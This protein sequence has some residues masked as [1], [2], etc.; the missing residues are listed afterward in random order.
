MR[1]SDWSSDVCSSDLQSITTLLHAVTGQRVGTRTLAAVR[2]LGPMTAHAAA[3]RDIQRIGL[4][5][6]E[7]MAR[8]HLEAGLVVGNVVAL[9][10]VGRF[11]CRSGTAL[12]PSHMRG[13]GDRK[14]NSRSRSYE[15]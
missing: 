7:R 3:A 6:V 14:S 1:I 11:L 13:A 9:I 2:G 8:H 10:L 15:C 4:R 5:R 12:H